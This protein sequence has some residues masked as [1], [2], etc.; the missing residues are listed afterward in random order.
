MSFAVPI[1]CKQGDLSHWQ[2][3]KP[4]QAVNL[5]A[6]MRSARVILRSAAGSGYCHEDPRRP[7]SS[8]RFLRSTQETV[9]LSQHLPECRAGQQ[10]GHRP[11]ALAHPAG[12]APCCPRWGSYPALCSSPRPRTSHL[13][14]DIV[15][16]KLDP[17]LGGSLWD[18]RPRMRPLVQKVV[19]V[20][21]TRG[22]PLRW[23]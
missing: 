2:L 3:L 9:P 10:R 7:R 5:A 21:A 23:T 11:D 17:G 14:L 4:Y 19:N 22:T 20:K 12:F 13:Q 8:I 1:L 15:R 18:G 6:R 16:E